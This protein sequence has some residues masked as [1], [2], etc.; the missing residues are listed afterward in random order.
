M[1][2]T[3]FLSREFHMPLKTIRTKFD[4][5]VLFHPQTESEPPTMSLNPKALPLLAETPLITELTLAF[6]RNGGVDAQALMRKLYSLSAAFRDGAKAYMPNAD[7]CTALKHVDLTLTWDDFHLPFSHLFV[8]FPDEWANRQQFTPMQDSCEGVAKD[9]KPI[10]GYVTKNGEHT[11]SILVYGKDHDITIDM[12][13]GLAKGETIE[14]AFR[15]GLDFMKR[16]PKKP[17]L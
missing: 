9:F 16:M 6:Y 8:K 4:D 15:A 11:I 13:R 10:W 3:T 12:I 14:D 2:M 17:R 1:D 5:W 7:T